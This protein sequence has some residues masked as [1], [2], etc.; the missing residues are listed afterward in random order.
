[1]KK[2]KK[3]ISEEIDR[4]ASSLRGLS[5]LFIIGNIEIPLD[6]EEFQGVG[7]LLKSLSDDL[8]NIRDKLRI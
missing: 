7:Y 3:E 4:A 5:G 1:M 2:E 6:H 8:K